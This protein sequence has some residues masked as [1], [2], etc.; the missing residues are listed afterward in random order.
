MNLNWKKILS[1][2]FI[3]PTLWNF[4]FYNNNIIMIASSLFF[5]LLLL[6]YL[7]CILS[8]FLLMPSSSFFCYI[9]HLMNIVEIIIMLE[10]GLKAKVNFIY[11]KRLSLQVFIFSDVVFISLIITLL[12]YYFSG[13]LILFGLEGG[14]DL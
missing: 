5:L 14:V 8:F 1:C 7:K 6:H 2:L 9:S 3:I 11:T 10:T 12:L 4:L 13:S